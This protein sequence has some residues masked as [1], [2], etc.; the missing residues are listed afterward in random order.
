MRQESW[1]WRYRT[2]SI[3]RA[4]EKDPGRCEVPGSC[5]VS[6]LLAVSDFW[7]DLQS[8]QFIHGVRVN[9]IRPAKLFDLTIDQIMPRDRSDQLRLVWLQAECSLQPCHCVAFGAGSQSR[10]RRFIFSRN[11]DIPS[12]RGIE[13]GQQHQR[14]LSSVALVVDAKSISKIGP[15]SGML[16]VRV[17]AGKG[18]APRGREP[19]RK[20]PWMNIVGWGRAMETVE[21]VV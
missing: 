3:D 12:H 9:S 17:A 5:D 18:E 21:T 16:T 1:P 7:P 6:L 10:Q 2:S 4:T 13:P 15:T 20:L 19:L 8:Q 11:A 14:E